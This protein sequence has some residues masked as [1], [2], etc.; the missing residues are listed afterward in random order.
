MSIQLIDV[1][2]VVNDGLG[3]DLR[4]AFLKINAN[5]T[6]L[7]L[8][9]QIT[10]SNVGVGAGVF[11]QK[12]NLTLE[13][14]KI[15]AGDNISVNEQ[16]LNIVVSSPLQNSFTIAKINDDTITATTPTST[17]EFEAGTNISITKTDDKI[18]ISTS[19][20][21]LELSLDPSPSLGASLDLNNYSII[22]S[23]NI[24]IDGNITANTLTGN[25]VG[26]VTGNLVGN[27][28]G[29]VNGL[30]VVQLSNTIV[31]VDFGSINQVVSNFADFV[32]A[33]VTY[34]MGT[35]SS[36]NLAN[37]DFGSI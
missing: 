2:N 26:N 8:R 5:F 33:M 27:V 12:N 36:P 14:R 24:N 19:F 37:I 21:T 15:T 34:D 30:D 23:G 25:L 3:D 1:G 17:I 4:T 9:Q 7:D 18:N 22:G 20:Q 6:D 32:L 11:K 31:D 16:D 28:T 13:F 10:G 29:L 35:F